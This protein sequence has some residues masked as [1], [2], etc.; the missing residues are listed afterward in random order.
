ML[1]KGLDILRG[2]T[3]EMSRQALTTHPS[4][5]CTSLIDIEYIKAFKRHFNQKS[6][7]LRSEEITDQFTE[8][9]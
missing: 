9:P 1:K 6:K 3:V 5:V 4:S 8:N 7:G 2:D